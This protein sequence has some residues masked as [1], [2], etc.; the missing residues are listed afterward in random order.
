[1]SEPK[2]EPRTV[3]TQCPICLRALWIE[4]VGD[5][6]E[7]HRQAIAAYDAAVAAEASSKPTR[8]R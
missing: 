5:C 3:A 7:T 8:D 6:I 1:M 4:G 2:P